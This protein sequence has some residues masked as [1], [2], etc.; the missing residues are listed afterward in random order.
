M[1]QTRTKIVVGDVNSK[2][3]K[4]MMHLHIQTGLPQAQ[5]LVVERRAGQVESIVL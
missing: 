1:A 4:A 5:V 2:R 3:C